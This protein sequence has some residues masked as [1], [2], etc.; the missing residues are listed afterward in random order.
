MTGF[1]SVSDLSRSYQLRVSQSS[2]KAKLDTLTEE[3]TTGV[4]ADIPL[5]L[6][7]DLQAVTQIDARIAQLATYA[8]NI[9]QAETR[10]T[11]MQSALEGIRTQAG[12]GATLMSEALTSSQ[13]GLQLHID[14]APEQLR[15]II[16]TL[17]TTVGGR[18]VFSGT[19]TDRA[20]VVDYDTMMGQIT[21]AVGGATTADTILSRIDAYFD[22]PAGGGGYADTGFQG[23]TGTTQIAADTQK[24]LRTDLTAG[25]AEIRTTLKGFAV[26][27]YLA[28][29]GGLDDAT[30][31]TLTEA[32]G[33]RMVAAQD[34]LV[35]AAGRLGVQQGI[36]ASLKTGNSAESST[37]AI[38]RNDLVGADPYDTA[39]ALKEVE[40][41]LETLYTVTSR[42]SQL[43][44][45]S[46]L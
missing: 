8:A 28:Q 24:T 1:N 22:S 7:G 27:A 40:A 11:G 34:G 43:S 3:T 18:Y 37:L 9:T 26:M 25:S 6:N 5:A 4:K 41:N 19:S 16:G 46:Y 23:D 45:M 31:R 21:A 36:A 35:S 42:L 17:N 33:T 29:Q 20:P 39:T 15:S 13:A 32:A 30:A 12:D 38:A 44:L 10:M 2:L 14:K